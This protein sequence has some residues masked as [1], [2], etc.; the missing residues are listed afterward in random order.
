M[1]LTKFVLNHAGIRELLTSS[2]MAGDLE[3]R[4]RAVANAAGPGHEVEVSTGRNRARA[5][6][7]TATFAAMEK[8]AKDRNLSR[9]FGAARG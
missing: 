2:A 1:A 5:S 7:R 9:A 8:E 4:A 6:V 3:R